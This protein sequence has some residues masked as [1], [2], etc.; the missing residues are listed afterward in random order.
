M[1]MRWRKQLPIK[2][3]EWNK[4]V[5]PLL[6]MGPRPNLSGFS[7]FSGCGLLAAS[8]CWA[9]YADRTG[10]DWTAGIHLISSA[11][12]KYLAHMI[13]RLSGRR[14]LWAHRQHNIKALSKH[15]FGDK[16]LITLNGRSC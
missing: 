7:M 12:L 1:I 8:R 3:F 5:S 2:R 13:L 6:A 10:G 14:Q 9:G 16:D 4:L 15:G 11:E